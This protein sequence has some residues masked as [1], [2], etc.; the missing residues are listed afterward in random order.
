MC[1]AMDSI[2]FSEENALLFCRVSK[3]VVLL[4]RRKTEI[5]EDMALEYDVSKNEDIMRSQSRN[6]EALLIQSEIH[7]KFLLLLKIMLKI[8]TKL[9]VI[10]HFISKI[11]NFSVPVKRN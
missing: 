4:S 5:K 9:L 3:S 6:Q 10:E 7:H 8:V 1:I 2:S 11:T